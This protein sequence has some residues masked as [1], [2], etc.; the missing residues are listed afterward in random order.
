MLTLNASELL[1][2][3]ELG[4][5]QPSCRQAML[6]LAAAYPEAGAEELAGLSIGRR[7]ARLMTLREW[8][9]G[10]RLVSMADC[11]AC[12]EKLE[13]S[14]DVSDILVEAG[15][16]QNSQ[17]SLEMEGYEILFRLPDS[18]DLAALATGANRD[19]GR[20]TVLK[21]CLTEVR[22]NGK[23]QPTEEL[24]AEIVRCRH[25]ADEHGRPP[26]GV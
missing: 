7:D 15:E 17:L 6:L 14:F 23:E 26:G 9:F 16:E 24:P 1:S 18:N 13:L 20:G 10:P 5:S 3:W 19:V 2:V 21:R 22:L 12:G 25:E 4:R 8:L 11:P